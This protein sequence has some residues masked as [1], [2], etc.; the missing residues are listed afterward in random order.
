M[1]IRGRKFD[2]KS[3]A[4]DRVAREKA[5]FGLPFFLQSAL[6]V[7]GLQ[8]ARTEQSFLLVK[9]LR[10]LTAA[11]ASLNRSTVQGPNQCGHF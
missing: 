4:G 10:N 5:G 2:C 8:E 1:I 3:T 9:Y 7:E 11:G 6:D